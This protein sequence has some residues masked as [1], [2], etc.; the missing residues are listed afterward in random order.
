[1]WLLSP[2]EIF[3]Q[4]KT[5][6][7]LEHTKSI[8]IIFPYPIH[9]PVTRVGSTGQLPPLLFT[10]ILTPGDIWMRSCNTNNWHHTSYIYVRNS[11][12]TVVTRFDKFNVN[13]FAHDEL[14]ILEIVFKRQKPTPLKFSLPSKRVVFCRRHFFAELCNTITRHPIELESCS[15][16]LRMREL[17]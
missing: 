14:R 7:P 5:S 9:R 6:Q 3:V 16:P 1:M 13:A 2:T 15:N 10:I 11:N 17:F 12:T 8:N 4:N